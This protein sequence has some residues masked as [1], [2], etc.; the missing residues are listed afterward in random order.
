MKL[1]E[2]WQGKRNG[3]AYIDYVCWKFTQIAISACSIDSLVQY[4]KNCTSV[5]FAK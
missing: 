3:V 4:A 2:Q 1:R 5:A